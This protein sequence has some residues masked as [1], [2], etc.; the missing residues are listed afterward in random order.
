MAEA[1][2]YDCPTDIT[3]QRNMQLITPW[4]GIYGATAIGKSI[5]EFNM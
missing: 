2:D 3:L 1:L 5:P 4:S